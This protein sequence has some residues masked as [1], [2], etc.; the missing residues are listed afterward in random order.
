[1][2]L[3]VCSGQR[4]LAS[5]KK[6]PQASLLLPQREEWKKSQNWQYPFEQGRNSAW[7]VALAGA[8]GPPVGLVMEDDFSFTDGACLCYKEE[9]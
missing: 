4:K 8:P 9:L 1:M 5:D 7:G 2:S 3:Y 6:I